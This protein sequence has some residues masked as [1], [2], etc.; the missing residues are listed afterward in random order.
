MQVAAANAGY[1]VVQVVPTM[2]N[3]HPVAGVTLMK[4]EAVKEVQQKLD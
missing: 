2:K 4:G 3:G 1:S